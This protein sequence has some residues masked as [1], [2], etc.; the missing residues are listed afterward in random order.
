MLVGRGRL[1]ER[2]QMRTI[3]ALLLTLALLC[4]A[5]PAVARDD[6]YGAGR[7]SADGIGKTYMGRE[8]AQVMG[9]PGADWLERG[10]RER[11]E[12]PDLLLAALALTPGMAVA[13]V[14]AGTGYYTWQI[15]GPIG[16]EGRVY[17]VDVQPQMLDLLKK[18]M[19]QR[20]VRN[21]EPVLGTATDTG[22]AP[23]SIDLALMVDVYHELDQ[24]REVV[25][26]LLRALRPGGRLVLVEYRAEDDSVP[27]KRLHKM[28]V[29][30]I[31][32]ELGAQGLLWQ[33]TV[34]TLPWQHIVIFRK[35]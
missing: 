13:D 17:A 10:S 4:G 18:N 8:I 29:A 31:R 2:T 23:A 24:P 12:R 15:A 1:A 5:H 20:G 9:Y 27:I 30:Q 26:S 7:P 11:E 14:G 34:E 35:P 32:R 3:P 16:Q 28:S 22:L 33:Q 21:V 19:R 25:D 6:Q